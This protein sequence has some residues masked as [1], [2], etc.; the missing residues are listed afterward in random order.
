MPC[1]TATSKNESSRFLKIICILEKF[2][3]MTYSHMPWLRPKT[4]YEKWSKK[5]KCLSF[6][7]LQLRFQHF[8]RTC[9]I[10]EVIAKKQHLASSFS[11]KGR[12][13]T[14]F[15]EVGKYWNA[16]YKVYLYKISAYCE[17]WLGLG[18]FW[19]KKLVVFLYLSCKCT[20]NI[21]VWYME[22]Y[23]V[24]SS[25]VLGTYQAENFFCQEGKRRSC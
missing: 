9:F 12:K 15:R 2:S 13:C 10:W 21:G 4:L 18:D 24:F 16:Y 20:W 8:F 5:W 6:G 1:K 14:D 3:Y 22:A 7:A 23:E 25:Y 11:Q 19:P 17:F